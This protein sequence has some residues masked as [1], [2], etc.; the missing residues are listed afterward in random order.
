MW[1]LWSKYTG[2]SLQLKKTG[3]PIIVQ[4]TPAQRGYGHPAM[5]AGMI[6]A[7]ETIYPDVCL[8]GQ[9]GPR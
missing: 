7:A 4:M 1:P 5:L 3:S 8:R 9:F 6:R 2:S